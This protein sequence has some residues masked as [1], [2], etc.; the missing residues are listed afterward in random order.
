MGASVW[1][2]DNSPQSTVTVVTAEQA[3]FF[4]SKV[5]PVLIAN[6]FTCHGEKE[7][8]GGIRLDARAH[9]LANGKGGPIVGIGSPETSRL[10]RAVRQSGPI[11]MPPNGK[12]RDTDIT[13]LAEW[14]KMGAPWPDRKTPIADARPAGG[15]ADFVIRPEQKN[16]WSFRPVKRPA[17]P[18][19]KNTAWILNPIDRFI[20]A[21]LEAK[22]LKPAPSATRPMLIRRAT[23]DLIGLPPT[24]EEVEAFVNDRSPNAWEKVIDRLLAAPQYGE[25]WGRRW[26]DLVRYADSNGLDEN[27][28]FAHAYLYRDYVISALNHDKPYN[29]F[30]MEQLAGDLMPSSSDT[31]RTERLTATGFLSLGPKVLAEPDKDK[32][33]MDIVDEQIEATSKAFL[34]LTVACARCHNHKFDPISTKDYYALAGIFKSTKTMQTLNTVAMWNERALASPNLGAERLA[35]EPKMMEARQAVEIAKLKARDEITAVFRKDA[36]KYLRAGWELAESGEP[37]SLADA[38]RKP[39]DAKRLFVEAEKFVRGNVAIDRD[40]WGKG[41]GIIYNVGTPDIAEWDI[42]LPAAGPYQFEFR[43]ASAEERPVKL[44]VNGKVIHESTCG[45]I[46]G[47]FGPDGQRWEVQGILPFQAGKNTIRIDRDGPIPHFDKLMLVAAASIPVGKPERSAEQIAKE[48]SVD[49]ERL[50]IAARLMK[51]HENPASLSADEQAKAAEQLV[52]RFGKT[53][54]QKPDSLYT[55]AQKQTVDA[56][57]NR[58]KAVEAGQPKPLMVMAV[59]EGRIADCKV[60][61][62]GDTTN[63]GDEA[64][65]RFLT[66]LCGDNQKPIDGTRSGRLELAEWLADSAHPLTSRVA[67]NRIW[68][69]HFGEGLVRT[70]DNWGFLGLQPTHPALLDWLASVFTE[71]VEGESGKNSTLA[72]YS[73]SLIPHPSSLACGWS[74]KRLHKLIMMSNAYKMSTLG[75]SVTTAKAGTEDPENRLLWRFNRRRMEAEPF[76]DS[77]LFVSGKL[78][79]KMGGSLLKTGNHDY[80]TNDQSGNAAQYNSPRR[81]IYLPIIRNALFDMFQAFDMGDPS[82]VN[83]KRNTTT[84]SPQALYVMNS[85]FVLEQSKTFA[86]LL[87]IKKELTDAQRLDMAYRKTMSRPVTPSETSR[88]LAFVKTYESRLARSEPDAAKRHLIAWSAACQVLFGSNEFIYVN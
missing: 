26:L 75:D 12:L 27:V 38:P 48:F 32:M 79:L 2:A 83:A 24:P 9:L 30:I 4:E 37:L 20:L 46:T 59:E 62:R 85:P 39:G 81:S 52:A 66:V 70:P 77:M 64:P 61:I 56:A 21:G 44:S 17:L 14:V 80:V 42:D 19:V 31:E 73:S 40:N 71:T 5:R 36:A 82:M 34:G 41:I 15:A 8:R 60:H 3:A 65:R 7:Q 74:F 53:I 68:Q 35:Y 16:F 67:V 76:R 57:M 72:A 1:A 43:Y 54:E 28:A 10:I 69:D 33:V 88:I 78:D 11:K 86:E 63:L 25:R 22:G 84:V 45:S 18:A 50:T 47:S 29:E 55:S 6:C 87:L 58:L 51:G 49:L 23:L 13:A